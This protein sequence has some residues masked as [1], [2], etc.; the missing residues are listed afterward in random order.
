MSDKSKI[1]WT[2]ATW[3]PITGCTKISR[4]CKFCYAE[5]DW[6]RLKHLPTYAGRDFSDVACHENRLDQPLRWQRPRKIF[7]NSMSDLFHPDVPDEFIDRV[8]AVMA[9]AN[10]HTFQV[11]TKRPERMLSYL[12]R[13]GR[14]ANL[15]NDAV[16]SLG[17][18]LTRNDQDLVSWPLPNVWIGVSIEDQET[19]DARV[20]VLLKSPAAKHWVSAEPLLGP[21]SFDSVPVGMFGALRP[22]GTVG[23]GPRIDFC[24]VGG[25]SGPKARPMHPDWARSIRDE[26]RKA[27]TPFFF[28]QTGLWQA[29][30]PGEAGSARYRNRTTRFMWNTTFVKTKGGGND[31]LDGQQWQEYPDT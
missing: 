21:V 7:V 26:C 9:V 14:S 15:L 17:H 28:K 13:L 11:L 12:L 1:S 29:L 3:N 22:F 8:F 19:A 23:V 25:E 30:E 2:S 31:L 18:S 6:A 4:A 24:V 5:R 27:N 20:P 16:R 10:R